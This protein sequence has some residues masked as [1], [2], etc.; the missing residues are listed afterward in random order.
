MSNRWKLPNI[1]HKG[2][3][4]VDVID[5][6]EDGQSEDETDYQTCMMCN[7]DRIR[8]V[9]IVSHPEV[10]NDFLVGC[11]CAEKMTGDYV[12][13]KQLENK[14]RQRTARRINWVKKPWKRSEKGNHFLN[15]EEHQLLIFKDSETKK[16]KCKIGNV[17]GKK[18][19][20]TIEQ[21]KHA[22]FNGID[23]LK[24]KGR[25]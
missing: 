25:W 8:Y 4:I 7:H 1:P 18:S 14:L 3:T 2:W 21:A 24:E 19:F 17:W 22:V 6:R 11:V 20:E 10:E 16:F 15:L 13:P 12:R 5:I 23:Y 9:H